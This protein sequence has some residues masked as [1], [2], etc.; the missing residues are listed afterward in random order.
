MHL[1]FLLLVLLTL[2][3]KAKGEPDALTE[4]LTGMEL[5]RLPAGTFLMGEE[6]KQHRETLAEPFWMGRT[7]VT[8]AQWEAVMGK[9]EPHPEKPSPFRGQHPQY[10]VVSISYVEVQ[11]FLAR[12]NH[13]GGPWV[14]RLPTEAQWE[15]ACRAGTT[16]PFY[17]GEVLTAAQANINAEIPSETGPPGKA[18]G[19]PTPVGSYPPNP[20]GLQD[21][22]GNAWE[23]VAAPDGPWLKGGSW[24]YGAGNARSGHRRAHRA[25]AWGFSIGFRVV[26]QR[27]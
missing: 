1:R 6:G 2:G 27:R 11:D 8:Q 4:P 26:A 16:T 15:Y 13:A 23:W 12:L 22:H 14:Y 21:M 20:W 7:E 5:V 19:H 24:Y 9:G 3:C 10:P 17:T 18:V 25:D